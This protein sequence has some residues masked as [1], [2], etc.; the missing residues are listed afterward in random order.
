M[1]YVVMAVFLVFFLLAYWFKL[2][3]MILKAQAKAQN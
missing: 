3:K 2:R 1:C